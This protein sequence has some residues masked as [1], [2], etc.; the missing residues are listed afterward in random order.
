M[1]ERPH[2]KQKTDILDFVEKAHACDHCSYRAK[3]GDHLKKHKANIHNIGVKWY[4]CDHC[5][6]KAKQKSNLK[7]HKVLKHNIGVTWYHCDQCSYRTKQKCHLKQHLKYVENIGDKTCERCYETNLGVVKPYGM[8]NMFIDMCDKCAIETGQKIRI[9]HRYTHYL[10]KHFDFPSRADQSLKGDV[11]HNYRPDKIYL[12]NNM[13]LH[14]EID[15]HEHQKKGGNYTCDEKRISEIY[16]E[17]KTMVPDHYIVIRL[18]PDSYS[19]EKK[20]Y[21]ADR[22]KV[23]SKRAKILVALMKKIIQEPPSSLQCVYYLY[24][25][26][27]SERIT[28]NIPHVMLNDENI[29]EYLK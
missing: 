18:N 19:T 28:K 5:S 22:D 2:K 1:E 11:C 25:S 17:F 23:F 7:H 24:Y 4:H 27:D 21:R 9:E 29:K 10:D 16:D 8:N 20:Y 26:E 14:I 15:E 6:F 13:I 3:R 12:G